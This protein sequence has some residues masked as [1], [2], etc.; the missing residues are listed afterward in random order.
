MIPTSNRME[1]QLMPRLE[2][3]I[4]PSLTLY[5]CIDA[6]NLVE[7]A[8]SRRV[9][10][11]VAPVE[12]DATTGLQ[13]LT[14]P[15][16]YMNYVGTSGHYSWN[17]KSITFI[18]DISPRDITPLSRLESVEF[19]YGDTPANE[20]L[21]KLLE[22]PEACPQLYTIAISGYPLWELLFEV[23]CRRN[24]SGLRRITRLCLPHL[25]VLQLMETLVRLL[26]GETAVFTT[27][28]VDELIVKRMASPQMWVP[29]KLWMLLTNCYRLCC[30]LCIQAGYVS[31]ITRSQ[32]PNYGTVD[33][34]DL[35]NLLDL[36]F[37]V[38]NECISVP[39]LWSRWKNYRSPGRGANRRSDNGETYQCRA[40]HP[41]LSVDITE[42]TLDG[43]AF[44]RWGS[45]LTVNF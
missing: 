37:P 42:H 38:D 31:C 7:L 11:S 22:I 44:Y 13:K 45:H 5:N 35:Q 9:I 10:Q 27:R 40:F 29:W 19:S 34:S 6:P 25:P 4:V 8:F 20:F 3:L 39:E 30:F 28:N 1:R 16:D 2:S 18:S 33:C 15:A 43:K 36:N 32:T 41:T 24:A 17:S 21:L 23:L 14:L 26:S 12:T